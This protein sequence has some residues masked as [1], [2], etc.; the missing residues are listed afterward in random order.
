MKRW[1]IALFWLMLASAV[2]A[3]P[4]EL[5]DYF[6]DQQPGNTLPARPRFKDESGAEVALSRYA[7]GPPLILVLGYFHCPNLCGLVRGNLLEALSNSGLGPGRDAA[8]PG[9]SR[10]EFRIAG[11]RRSQRRSGSAGTWTRS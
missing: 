5:H 8:W 1:L 3:A 11:A 7:G 4:E 9:S 10:A 2:Q 6:Y